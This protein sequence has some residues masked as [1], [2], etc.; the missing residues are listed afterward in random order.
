MNSFT[1]ELVKLL[2]IET[3]KL[4]KEGL[5]TY[6]TNMREI[7]DHLWEETSQK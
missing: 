1:P 4:I 6:L 7:G 5:I 2:I 3:S